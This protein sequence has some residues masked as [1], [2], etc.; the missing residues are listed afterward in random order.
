[1]P[2]KPDFPSDEAYRSAAFMLMCEEAALRAIAKVESGLYGAFLDSG[3]PTIL[4][5]RHLFHRETQ[6]KFDGLRVPNESG[7]WTVISLSSPGGY[8]PV[9]AQ[10]TK[11]QF[12]V[13]LNRD[14][15]LRSCSWGLFQILGSNHAACGYPE[16]QRFVNA[17]YRSADDHL[18]ALT[19][20]IRH[21]HRLVDAIR[22]KNWASFA[23]IYNGPGYK[24]NQYDVK[25]S[26][27]YDKLRG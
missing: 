19:M 17:M 25:M 14:A 2:T 20:F 4:F 15:A 11:L 12:A 13:H 6:G 22:D 24:K 10:H 18:R 3:E 21:V 23:Y 1:M 26:Q 7:D 16:L 8:G 9:S 27:A 5:E